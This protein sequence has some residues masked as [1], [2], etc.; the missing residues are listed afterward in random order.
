LHRPQQGFG[1]PSANS[2]FNTAVALSPAAEEVLTMRGFHVKLLVVCL[3]S[4]LLAGS[5]LAAPKLSNAQIEP[6]TAWIGDHVV[7]TVAIDDPAKEVARVEGV[8]VEYP[9]ITTTLNDEGKGDDKTAG[10]GIWSGGADVPPE[11]FEGTYHIAIWPKSAAGS[12]FKVDGEFVKATVPVV[13]KQPEKTAQAPAVPTLSDATIT[14][15]TAWIGDHIV[16]TVAIADPG[17]QVAKVEGVVVEYPELVTPMNDEG[18]GDDKV[19][20]DGIW[21]GGA[22][23]PS[24][25]FEGTYH[26]AIW[27]K[28]AAGGAFKVDGEFVKA[29]VVLTLKPGAT[30][31]PAAP[32]PAPAPA[33]TGVATISNAKVEPATVKPGDHVVITATV[34]DPAKTVAKV[35]AIVTEY[36]VMK[37]PLNDEG[38]GDDKTAGDG[39]YTLG[40]N[41]PDEAPAATYHL[42]IS[43]LDAA[44]NAI[45][46]A[47]QPLKATVALD[48]K[49]PEP[50]AEPDADSLRTAAAPWR[51]EAQIAK[52]KAIAR[53]PDEP[54]RFVVMGDSRSNP[55]VF[56]KLLQIAAG[57]PK[58]DF[59]INSGDIVPGG[60]PAEYAFFFTQ[61]KDVTWPFLI[62]EGNHELG[63]SG[64]RLYEELFGPTDYYFDH[65]GIR[66]VA[67]NNSKGVVTPQQLKWLDQALTTKLRKIVAF[68][69]PPN[70]IREW[71]FHSFSM[72]AEELADLLAKKK[73][74]RVYVGHIHGFDVANYKGVE[75]V[76]SGGGGAGLSAQIAPGNFHNIV[77][78][79]VEPKG[80]RETVYRLDGSSF[81][82][83]AKKW[84][85]GKGQ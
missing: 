78:V 70:V 1:I 22:N 3:V 2:S 85:S 42:E 13:I 41:I 56:A 82:I 19:A 8:V 60:K 64:G 65:G 10:D 30:E 17:K 39:I 58:F 31:Q 54:F 15:S 27:P 76:L 49:S 20:G 32:T 67:L 34:A 57:L 38:K 28:S 63:P 75:Y 4:L 62:V 51:T 69:I 43:A 12:A 9:E 36:P 61:I 55:E 16:V 26:I 33:A 18:K 77:L 80:L 5:A 53:K 72:G 50:V 29:T 48:V 52:I 40:F 35:E 21:T 59:S 73:V 37:L 11:A 25:A 83:D 81:V 24:E 44:G 79:E 66:F 47:G 7:I 6:T 84:I 71:A 23:V 68:H 45:Q 14:P 46:V 74:E